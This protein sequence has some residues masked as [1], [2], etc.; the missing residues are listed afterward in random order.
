MRSW[1][2][3]VHVAGHRLLFSDQLLEHAAGA[4][5]GAVDI[6]QHGLHVPERVRVNRTLLRLDHRLVFVQKGRA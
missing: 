3:C 5:A 2:R 4:N 1:L 6:E